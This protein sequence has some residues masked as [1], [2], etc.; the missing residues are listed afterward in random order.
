MPPQSERT[1]AAF[2]KKNLDRV[3]NKSFIWKDF[4]VSSCKKGGICNQHIVGMTYPTKYGRFWSPT[5]Q[6]GKEHEA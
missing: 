3:V 2:W 4:H 6:V 5:S 1:Q